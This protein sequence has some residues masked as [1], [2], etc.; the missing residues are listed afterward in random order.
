MAI[1][2]P[3]CGEQNFNTA[4]YCKK[5]SYMFSDSKQKKKEK[6]NKRT[7]IFDC[8]VCGNKFSIE[9]NYDF[10]AFACLNC[11]SIFSYEWKNDSL[12]INVVKREEHVPERIKKLIS[13]FKL[14]LPLD[15]DKL[16][17]SYHK[18]ISLYHPDKVSHLADDFKELSNRKTK[19]IIDNYEA[20]Q[21][22]IKK[23]V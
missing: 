7:T 12:L 4:S 16:K 23:A 20:L 21:K 18:L 6:D 5:C 1:E 14:D 15:Q 2:C 10:Y 11:R 13:F 19:E 17:S 22:W 3:K 9:A 8:V